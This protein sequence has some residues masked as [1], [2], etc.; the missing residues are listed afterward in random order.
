M[1]KTKQVGNQLQIEREDM[2]IFTMQ[3]QELFAPEA[4]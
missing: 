1:G 3:E 4:F 2:P